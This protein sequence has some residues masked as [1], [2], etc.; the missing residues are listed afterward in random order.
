[1]A[2]NAQHPTKQA[3]RNGRLGEKSV[4]HRGRAKG[5]T[6]DTISD[7]RIA[8]RSKTY[9]SAHKLSCFASAPRSSVARQVATSSTPS[10]RRG[11]LS[12]IGS[13]SSLAP[14]M[15][16]IGNS[17]LRWRRRCVGSA[18]EAERIGG[19]AGQRQSRITP[20]GWALRNRLASASSTDRCASRCIILLTARAR[21]RRRGSAM[22]AP[23]PDLLIEP[24]VRISRACSLRGARSAPTRPVP[25]KW[26]G[27]F[28]VD[29]SCTG[30][31][32]RQGRTA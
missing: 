21:G 2:S 23:L 30:V 13:E 22:S 28:L 20:D 19:R 1:M 7:P 16:R 25:P 9:A 4:P 27:T 8:V 24:N 32:R 15:R 26:P 31:T 5:M 17:R 29:P 12:V 18:L 3:M 10:A 11:T 6:E 14:R